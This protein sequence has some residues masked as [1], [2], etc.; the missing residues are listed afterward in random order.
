M[1]E[2]DDKIQEVASSFPNVVYLNR[3]DWRNEGV[4]VIGRTLWTLLTRTQDLD[5][6]DNERLSE[7]LSGPLE[8]L[9][10]ET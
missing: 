7:H 6:G 5:Q 4:F 1:K 2:V 3:S 10:G 9:E 8:L